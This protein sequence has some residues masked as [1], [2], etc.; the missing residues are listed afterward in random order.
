MGVRPRGGHTAACA[1]AHCNY[2]A[3]PSPEPHGQIH[4][5]RRLE[6]PRNLCTTKFKVADGKK[7]PGSNPKSSRGSPALVGVEHQEEACEGS[8]GMKRGGRGRGDHRD[9]ILRGR[10][11]VSL[12]CRLEG[13]EDEAQGGE[14]QENHEEIH[15]RGT[16]QA[17]SLQP[18]RRVGLP[19]RRILTRDPANPPS[20]EPARSKKRRCPARPVG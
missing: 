2:T 5:V 15:R 18:D 1:A 4:S 7:H 14:L 12:R 10:R 16:E 17:R 19:C 11:R 13:Q 8:G 9:R 3:R 20:R 6:D